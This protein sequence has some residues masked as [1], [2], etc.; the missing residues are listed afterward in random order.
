MAQTFQLSPAYSFNTIT[1]LPGSTIIRE[2]GQRLGKQLTSASRITLS[3]R[4]ESDHRLP[5]KSYPD[6]E[7]RSPTQRRHR[8]RRVTI[9]VAEALEEPRQRAGR[10]LDSGICM[11]AYE[12]AAI[13]DR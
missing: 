10:S 3:P 11:P 5:R 4:F 13:I 1:S 12:L 8:R 2:R 6:S 7:N 9:D